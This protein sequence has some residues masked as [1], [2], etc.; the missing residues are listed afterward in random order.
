MSKVLDKIRELK[1]RK[2]KKV[3]EILANEKK[4]RDRANFEK[5]RDNRYSRFYADGLA[6]RPEYDDKTFTGSFIPCRIQR[7]YDENG[8]GM[9][10]YVPLRD[11]KGNIKKISEEEAFQIYCERGNDI[12]A[13]YPSKAELKARKE[14]VEKEVV[15]AYLKRKVEKIFK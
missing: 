10:N 11:E 15:K 5:V 9:S 14:E 2:A 7:M 13:S 6:Y 3:S 4:A 8:R 12:Y 1:A